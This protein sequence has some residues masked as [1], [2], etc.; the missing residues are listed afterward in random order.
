MDTLIEDDLREFYR[1][2]DSIYDPAPALERLRTTNERAPRHRHRLW[3]TAAACGTTLAGGITAAVLLLGA[4][5]PSAYAGWSS[6]PRT[7]PQA[8]L[9]KLASHCKRSA[10]IVTNRTYP[11]GYNTGVVFSGDPVLTET[12]GIFTAGIY[13][14]KGRVYSCMYGARGSA[15]IGHDEDSGPVEPS[16]GPDQ[17]SAPYGIAFAPNSPNGGAGGG[18]GSR[19]VSPWLARIQTEM[20]HVR[21]DTPA[22]QRLVRQFFLLHRGGGYGLNAY[23]QA[24]SD[25]SAVVFSFANGRTVTATVQNGWY[26]AWWPWTS[27]PNSVQVSTSTGTASSPMHTTGRGVAGVKASPACRPGTTGC[28]FADTL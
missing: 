14:T 20:H 1:A 24:G 4:S 28:V 17:I 25:V 10:G 18:D 13:V 2:Y 12:R 21:L 5:T 23:G 26:F 15:W 16:P 6:T 27:F 9:P 11:N 8:Q 19:A 22:G 7:V 3:A